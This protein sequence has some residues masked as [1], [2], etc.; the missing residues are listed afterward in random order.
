MRREFKPTIRH[1]VGSKKKKRQ[2]EDVVV[3]LTLMEGESTTLHYDGSP[4][5]DPL[6]VS[7][8]NGKEVGEASIGRYNTLSHIAIGLGTD[9]ATD[10]DGNDRRPPGTDNRIKYD[11][12]VGPT[13]A[14]LF[15]DLNEIPSNAIIEEAT[16][17]LEPIAYDQSLDV[18]NDDL[19][20]GRSN[21]WPSSGVLMEPLNLS[22]FANE[23]ATWNYGRETT[24]G[25]HSDA[26][27]AFQWKNLSIDG[28]NTFPPN[29]IGMMQNSKRKD[30]PEPQEFY[31]DQRIDLS[32]SHPGEY[33][34]HIGYGI[35]GGGIIENWPLTGHETIVQDTLDTV[36]FNVLSQTQHG[37][38]INQRCHL[39]LRASNWGDNTAESVPSDQVDILPLTLDG[40]YISDEPDGAT[41]ITS[42]AE[43]QVIHAV[44]TNLTNATSVTYEWYREVIVPPDP[45]FDEDLLTTKS[46]VPV[47]EGNTVQCL[48]FNADTVGGVPETN[49][50]TFNW[51]STPQGPGQSYPEDRILQQTTTLPLGSTDIT[52]S[53]TIPNTLGGSNLRCEVILDNPTDMPGQSISST[54]NYFTIGFDGL[55]SLSVNVTTGP[56]DVDCGLPNPSCGILE[57]GSRVQVTCSV[58]GVQN[59]TLDYVLSRLNPDSSIE[60]LDQTLDS[61]SLASPLYTIDLPD[62]VGDGQYYLVISLKEDDVPVDTTVK[63]WT[64]TVEPDAPALP[65]VQQPEYRSGVYRLKA[66]SETRCRT[67][68]NR[69]NPDFVPG[70]FGCS[71]PNTGFQS[72]PDMS[73]TLDVEEAPNCTGDGSFSGRPYIPTSGASTT[74]EIFAFLDSSQGGAIPQGLSSNGITPFFSYNGSFPPISAISRYGFGGKFIDSGSGCSEQSRPTD[75][76]TWSENGG[77]RYFISYPYLLAGDVDGDECNQEVIV[78][79][80]SGANADRG[81]PAI[82]GFSSFG[83]FVY[84]NTDTNVPYRSLSGCT[85]PQNAPFPR[86]LGLNMLTGWM[87]VA[88]PE[89]PTGGPGRL[90]QDENPDL[91]DTWFFHFRDGWSAGMGSCGGGFEPADLDSSLHY[92][93]GI[94]VPT[95]DLLLTW[96]APTDADFFTG[97]TPPPNELPEIPEANPLLWNPDPAYELTFPSHI[98]I[99]ELG[100]N[101]H[102]PSNFDQQMGACGEPN[103]NFESELTRNESLHGYIKFGDDFTREDNPTSPRHHGPLSI[104]PLVC[105]SYSSF[106]MEPDPDHPDNPGYL[107]DAGNPVPPVNRTGLAMYKWIDDHQDFKWIMEVYR[108][109]GSGNRNL[110]GIIS[111]SHPQVIGYRPDI[112]NDDNSVQFPRSVYFQHSGNRFLDDSFYRVGDQIM[113]YVFDSQQDLTDAIEA[114]KA[115][116]AGAFPG[117]NANGSNLRIHDANN[118]ID[119]GIP[120]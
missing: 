63:S 67:Q 85:P 66:D 72:L 91:G 25:P 62:E 23:N 30:H 54:E 120:S 24:S 101:P 118:P 75:L 111:S 14:A 52:N 11:N 94:P 13:R 36:S 98:M 81:D 33:Y 73:I 113:F 18:F 80:D 83:D 90:N 117:I 95:D 70:E 32:I 22:S 89:L 114:A 56:G 38:S 5:M 82:D 8:P 74:K 29:P 88:G 60:T 43:D 79:L 37:Y 51:Y 12:I 100:T 1:F 76:A 49:R 92:P 64:Y 7:D 15:F 28:F 104:M 31:D 16:L 40:V 59:P 108:H 10:S 45:E 21:V 109:D 71:A 17:E 112:W 78:A 46:T 4:I 103:G 110:H 69:R 42:A 107:D 106:C 47:Q 48:V 97:G 58:T 2:E 3:D 116:Y 86:P 55:G 77:W 26:T 20:E 115:K 53:F 39:L 68:P 50:Y 105:N 93:D 27:K 41:E 102:A 34:G 57:N 44:P 119:I 99:G 61:T 87:Q 35:F 19:P 96:P 84:R 65:W 9:D 6:L